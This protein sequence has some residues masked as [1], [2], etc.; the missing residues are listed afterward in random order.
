MIW[1]VL[2]G[3]GLLAFALWSTLEFTWLRLLKGA[4]GS[5]PFVSST[6]RVGHIFFFDS[7]MFFIFPFLLV[8]DDHNNLF[9]AVLIAHRA[10]SLTGAIVLWQLHLAINNYVRAAHHAQKEA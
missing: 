8:N 4:N 9:W 3:L 10:V 7:M 6:L 5:R 2:V 1:L